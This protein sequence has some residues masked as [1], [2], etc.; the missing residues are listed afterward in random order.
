[1]LFRSVVRAVRVLAWL[2]AGLSL[3]GVL[4]KLLPVGP[5]VNGQVLAL[6]V[7]INLGLVAGVLAAT[8][9]APRPA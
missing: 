5:Q 7:P 3:A 8:R 6:L 9:P 1:M 2:V 4:L